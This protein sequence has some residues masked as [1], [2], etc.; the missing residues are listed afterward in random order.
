[1]IRKLLLL[2]QLVFYYSQLFAQI[3][4]KEIANL[5]SKESIER[6]WLKLRESDQFYR[7]KELANDSID[8][9]NFKEMILMIKY[10]GYPSSQKFPL[11]I[12]M[13]PNL[14][15]IHQNSFHVLKYYFPIFVK[16]FE[17]GDADSSSSKF[18]HSLRGVFISKYGRNFSRKYSLDS[19]DLDQVLKKCGIDKSKISFDITKFDSLERIDLTFRKKIN[20]SQLIGQWKSPKDYI[21]VL[22]KYKD[23]YFLSKLFY[24][25][26][27]SF[28]QEMIEIA[29]KRG[30]K[31]LFKEVIFD[32]FFI[33]NNRNELEVYINNQL[34]YT[35]SQ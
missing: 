28:P 19:F 14:I 22:N 11:K 2:I 27:S 12:N 35:I 31:L 21:F 6:Y 32:D 34:D 30:L 29:D 23:T 4:E 24:D 20:S 25:N 18:L 5:K 10:H 7:G 13:T 1:M 26:S 15:C 17:N 16:A 3:N 8:S 9:H 33:V